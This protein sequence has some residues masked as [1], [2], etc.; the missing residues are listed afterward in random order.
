MVSA[1]SIH[2]LLYLLSLSAEFSVS[3]SSEF[4]EAVDIVFSSSSWFP[5]CSVCLVSWSEFK[6]PFSSFH[7]PSLTC[8]DAILQRQSPFHF[9]WAVIHHRI[10]AFSIFSM[11]SSV[12]VLT[13][14]IHSSFLN[15]CCV[16]FIIGIVLERYVAVL[17]VVSVFKAL[18]VLIFILS[19]TQVFSVVVF[20]GLFFS[21]LDLFVSP[22]RF[23]DESKH[24]ALRRLN[25]SFVLF[26][27]C[28]GSR[29][30]VHR[31]GYH[32]VEKAE[33]DV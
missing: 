26:C 4:E 8:R 25:H 30:V 29:G 17:I 16:N 33:V 1:A 10:F 27:E 32:F 15:R 14:S 23:Y 18:S 5:N 28:P 12:L 3:F 24:F 13:F 19:A 6:F 31:R 2:D 21:F 7:Y 9:L 20:V 11:A 22:F